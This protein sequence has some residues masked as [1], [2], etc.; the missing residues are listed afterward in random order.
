MPAYDW[1]CRVCGSANAAG[2][3]ACA[4]CGA[5]AD[6]SADDILRLRRQRGLET[7]PAAEHSAFARL[8]ATPRAWLTAAYA[9]AIALATLHWLTCGGDMCALPLHALA[10]PWSMIPI[11]AVF[12]EPAAT[13]ASWLPLWLGFAI[14]ARLFYAVGQVIER[15]RDRT[16]SGS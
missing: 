11:A 6:L 16:A 12:S 2:V 1:T 4:N 10:L 13:A 3:D 7:V 9:L 14:N 5:Q 15:L 8:L